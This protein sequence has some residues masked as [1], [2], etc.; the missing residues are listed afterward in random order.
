MT[1][2][3]GLLMLVKVLRQIIL[4]AVHVQGCRALMIIS[5]LL[6]LASIIVSLF[7]M[8]CIH[9]GSASDESKA[10]IAVGGG[11]VSILGGEWTKHK[12][13]FKFKC[14]HDKAEL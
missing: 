1:V 9:V 3:T 13:R 7:G 4:S 5:L 11:I 14:T 8:Q 10:K 2:V 6:G 12:L